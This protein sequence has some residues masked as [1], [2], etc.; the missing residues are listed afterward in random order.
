MFIHFSA[1]SNIRL[2]QSMA[3]FRIL[4]HT[5]GIAG[6][7]FSIKVVETHVRVEVIGHLK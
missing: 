7:T 5:K 6:A 4:I 2:D 1:D 3:S